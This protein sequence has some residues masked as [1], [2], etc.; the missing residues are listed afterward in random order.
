M[1]VDGCVASGSREILILPVGDVEVGLWVA[2]LFGE[3]KVDDVDLVS[4]FADSHQKVVGLD[5][6]MDE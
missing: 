6:A 2:V 3:T 5:V 4:A 1:G